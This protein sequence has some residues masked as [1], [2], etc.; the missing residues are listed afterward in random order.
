MVYILIDV[1]ISYP[2]LF[3]PNLWINRTENL[4]SLLIIHGL[5]RVIIQ[6]FTHSEKPLILVL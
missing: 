2:T 5:A 4:V 3:Y 1:D 6:D